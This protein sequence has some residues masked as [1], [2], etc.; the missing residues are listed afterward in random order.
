MDENYAIF[1]VLRLNFLWT[2]LTKTFLQGFSPYGT[3]QFTKFHFIVAHMNNTSL[4]F[5]KHLERIL[6]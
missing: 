6:K 3:F 2:H 5:K 4:M 1:C